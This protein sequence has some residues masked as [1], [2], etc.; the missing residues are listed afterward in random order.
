VLRIPNPGSNIDQFI[1]TFQDLHPYLKDKVY[2][3]LDDITQ[4]MIAKHNVTS[5]GAIGPEALRRSQREDRSRDPIYNQSK[6]Y[7]ELYRALGWIHSTESSLT[8]RFTALGHHLATAQ[9]PNAL[10]RECFLSMAFPN[11]VLAV[12]GNQTVRAIG[13]SL[14]ALSK[15]QT[16]SRDEMIVGP[17]SIIDDT[18]EHAIDAMIDDIRRM[19]KKPGTLDA[20]LDEISA[21]RGIKRGSTMTNYVRVPM[22]VPPWAGWA[23]RSSGGVLTVSN[24]GIEAAKRLQSVRDFRL[25][26]F[27]RSPD[28]IKGPL[29]VTSSYRLL[30]RGGFDIGGVAKIVEEGE[31]ALAK[32]GVSEPI[33]F[34]P[35]QQLSNKTIGDYAP[36]MLSTDG[37]DELESAKARVAEGVA[38]YTATQVMPLLVQT[39]TGPV[40]KVGRVAGL[41]QEL[42]ELL[43]NEGGMLDVV[44]DKLHRRY[45]KANKDVF[46]PLIA[47][48]LTI[49]GFDCHVSRHGVNSARED[50][51]I[52]DAVHCIPVEIKSPGE[53]VE[54]SVKG[55][56]Q[57]L[58]NKIILLAREG[59]PH[60]TTPLTTSLVVG[61]NTPNERSEV[62]ELIDDIWAT[63]KVNVGVIDFRTLLLLALKRIHA[64]AP[65]QLD[66]ITH[67]RGVLRVETTASNG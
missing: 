20:R 33:L 45:A 27:V 44:A 50:A 30:E 26:D 14:I 65:L 35:F 21:A 36:S 60:V 18:T 58:E 41:E 67:Q 53:E 46:Y 25:H 28:K 59:A 8:F 63:Y 10:A 2:F 57:A 42:L 5:Q 64:R 4:A 29:I 12:R 55:V 3:G 56:R 11:E 43:S 54:I 32:A 47:D 9:D 61:Y 34:S 51:L 16:L 52:L 1:R 40:K 17:M 66:A 49:A 19:R 38:P 15:L 6:M 24:E 13:T 62:H 37:I 39:T 22:A 23:T 7:S 31:R 48:L